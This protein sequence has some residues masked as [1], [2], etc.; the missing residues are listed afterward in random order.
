MY[1]NDSA[2][3]PSD[4]STALAA[5]I[6]PSTAIDQQNGQWVV[7][8]VVAPSRPA[9]SGVVRVMHALRR[10]W[11]LASVL[12]L[13]CAAAAGPAVYFGYGPRYES[14][15]YLRISPQEK[16]ILKASGEGAQIMEFDI[17]KATQQQLIKSRFVLAHALRGPAVKE[18]NLDERE[19][20]P[21]TWLSDKL[22]VNFPGKAEIMEVSMAIRNGEE[23]Q[24]L[25]QAV[26]DA[27][28]SQ[29]IAVEKN[30]RRIRLDQLERAQTEHSNR[31]RTRRNE[32]RDLAERLGTT[33]QKALSI[34]QQ[35]AMEQFSAF[36]RSHMQ[37]EFELRK[38]K[39]ELDTQKALLQGID[40]LEISNFEVEQF[41]KSDPLL[42]QILQELFWRKQ[43]AMQTALRIR[44]SANSVST[45]NVNRDLQLVNDEYN[46][47]LKELRE[48]VRQ[49]KK[50]KIEEE[51][52]KREIEVASLTGQLTLLGKDVEE[53]RKQAERLSSSSVDLEMA[54]NEIDQ[55]ELVL[56]SIADEKERLTLEINS[57]E[58]VMLAQRAELPKQEYLPSI[59]YSISALAMIVGFCIPV[60]LVF[61]LDVRKQRVDSLTQVRQELGVPVAGSI[62]VIPARII[63]RL[64]SPSR[65]S[66]LWQL[67]LT[68]AVDGIAAK[69]LRQADLDQTRVV[70]VSSAAAGEGKTT[71]ATQLAL[72]LARSG[73][74][75]VLV[76]F[77]LR[78]PA[79]DAVFDLPLEPGICDVLR[80]EADV[81]QLAQPTATE[82]LSLLT[83]G[84]WDRQ[85]LTTLANDAAG[86]VF[87]NLREE[88]EFI[89]VDSSPVLSVA[90]T[91]F[92][93][94][95][96]DAVLLSVRRDASRAPEVEAA[97]E[98]LEVFGVKTMEAVFVGPGASRSERDLGYETQLPV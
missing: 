85:A 27:Y 57:P 56:K 86:A 67:R 45:R 98:I 10:H 77:D 26:V 66:Q 65:K 90:D 4:L 70:L 22:R 7:P 97:R 49:S 96:A 92:V 25:V 80:G 52:L 14:L 41:A 74:R 12:G 42:N 73:R 48:G 81:K 95:H 2:S 39:S 23:S 8:Q 17:Y 91:R 89:V 93:S 53:K 69:L 68:E 71:L 83:A 28:L 31:I 30:Q 29:V 87:E 47:K 58:R 18:L 44:A 43:E 37:V 1:T 19:N 21:V 34:K 38:A 35:V 16:V 13:L 46:E 75:T 6:R 32:L 82:G 76:D 3:L 79:L 51:K 55:L 40:D 88:Y 64:G 59:R 36:Q 33:D 24:L 62:P 72:S 60:G 63:R 15:A 84:R 9:S 78:R 54:R 94:Q 61:W 11:L 20:D 50:I 5:P